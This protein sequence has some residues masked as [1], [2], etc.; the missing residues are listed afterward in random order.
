M[1]TTVTKT[2]KASGGDYSSLSSW[3]A[4]E[5]RDLTSVDEIAEAQIDGTWSSADTATVLIGGWTTDATRYISIYTTSTCRH[6][7]KWD[8]TKYRIDNS[9]NFETGIYI[10]EG[11]VRIDGVQIRMTGAT[12]A[13]T[14]LLDNNVDAGGEIRF[15]NIIGWYNGG[16]TGGS[17]GLYQFSVGSGSRTLKI[18]NCIFYDFSATDSNGIRGGASWTNYIYNCTFQNCEVGIRGGESI[19]IAKNTVIQDCVICFLSMTSGNNNVSDDNTQPGTS[20]Q[21][22]EVTFLNEAGD[23]FHLDSS[24][25]VAKDNGADLSG[26]A[27]L[28]FSTDIDGQTRSSPWDCGADEYIV[29][30]GG[31]GVVIVRRRT[32]IV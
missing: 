16:G 10:S 9:G 25:T 1:P 13:Y 27:N 2:V 20:G 23:D 29:V 15:S 7:G 22:G 31:G 21:N 8:T 32:I 26:D 18:W 24:D 14:M 11:F 28:A 6:T 12:L 19:C 4:G 5:Q 17:N 3:E 30:G